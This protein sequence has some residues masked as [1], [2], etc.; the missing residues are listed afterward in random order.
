MSEKPILFSTSMVRAIFTGGETGPGARPMHPDWARS[1][2]DQC[3]VSGTPFFF[4]SWGDWAPDEGL[5]PY[6][7]CRAIL[8]ND[9]TV[10]WKVGKKSAGRLL[11]GREWSQYPGAG[12]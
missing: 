6:E 4:K 5:T 9:N 10:S 1:L 8:W 2:R 3:Q 12:I 7:G 11:D